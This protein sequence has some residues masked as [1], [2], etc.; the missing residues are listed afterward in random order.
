[1]EITEK[2]YLC[3]KKGD[4]I[5]IRNNSD[6][7]HPPNNVYVMITE[8]YSGDGTSTNPTGVSY[9]SLI[10]VGDSIGLVNMITPFSF[11]I[12]KMFLINN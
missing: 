5:F 3:L 10:L 9:K 12:S 7:W 6:H 4:I 1:M 11:S 2:D 8:R